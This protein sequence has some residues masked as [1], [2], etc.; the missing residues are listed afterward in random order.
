[1]ESTDG[2][3]EHLVGQLTADCHTG[4]ADG[5]NQVPA[6]GDLADP[7]LLAKA[8]VA[9][10]ITTRPAEHADLDVAPCL[11]LIQGHGIAVISVCK[12]RGHPHSRS[13]IEICLQQET[14]ISS[15]RSGPPEREH[16]NLRRA[17]ALG[18]F[19]ATA[20]RPNFIKLEVRILLV[21]EHLI[22]I[23]LASSPN[24]RISLAAVFLAAPV[25]RT[26]ERMELPSVRQRM[27]IRSFFCFGAIHAC[28]K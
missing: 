4:A 28:M 8:E 5:T 16:G 9:E 20:E 21:A 1:L 25:I 6:I 27:I 19:L 22:R 14:R 26:V 11:D 10:A 12:G 2:T 17:G 23:P 24:S 7:Q 15:D 18:L 3:H 13:P